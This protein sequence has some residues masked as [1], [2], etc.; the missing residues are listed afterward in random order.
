MSD[1]SLRYPIGRFELPESVTP[2]KITNWISI[3]RNFPLKM[4]EAVNGMTTAQLNTVYRE[5][6]WSIRQVVHH[7]ADSHANAYIRFKLALTEDNPTIKPYEEAKWAE[8]PDGK[9][10][11]IELSLRML[12][13]LH[14]RWAIVLENM[15]T[16]DFER[17]YVH[18]EKNKTYSL[19]QVLANYAWH[20]DHHLMHIIMT[21]TN[22]GWA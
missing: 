4:R 12:E 19:G 5:G 21:R 9:Y 14:A 22:K 18:P 6:G 3:I 10:G 7:S 15:S 17:T 8:L 2:E 11:E 16:S 13:T 20:C 1:E